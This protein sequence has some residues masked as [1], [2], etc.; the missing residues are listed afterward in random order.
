MTFLSCLS[1]GKTVSNIQ[2]AME[3][4]FDEAAW[5]EPSVIVFDDLD[6]IAPAPSGPE[7]E[8]NGETLYSAKNSQGERNFT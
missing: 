5:R 4:V 2:K 3:A 8:I 1:P 6:T 7:T